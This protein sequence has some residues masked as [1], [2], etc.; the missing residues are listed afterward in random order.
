VIIK[1]A[2]SVAQETGRAPGDL[3]RPGAAAI[4]DY[5]MARVMQPVITRTDF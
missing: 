1:L 3:H 2:S 5:G 4:P